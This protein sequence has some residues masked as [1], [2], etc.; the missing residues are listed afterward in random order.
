MKQFVFH[1]F[2]KSII[3]Q[4]VVFIFNEMFVLN[5]FL[6]AC[7]QETAFYFS[8]LFKIVFEVAYFE[9]FLKKGVNIVENLNRFV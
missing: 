4:L 7:K 5:V 2:F 6:K 8:I 1:D 9:Y 3:T